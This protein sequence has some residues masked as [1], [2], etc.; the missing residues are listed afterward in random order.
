MNWTDVPRIDQRGAEA[1]PRAVQFRDVGERNSRDGGSGSGG[2]GGGWLR[3]RGFLAVLA[4]G[5]MTLG[6]TVL[7]WIPLAR[8][9]RA[10]E[11]T[12]YLTCGGYSDGPGGPLCV[13]APYS[14]DYCGSDGWFAYGCFSDG[15]GGMDCY[16]P[17]AGCYAESNEARNA[18]RWKADSYTYRCADGR[19]HHD[20]APNPEFVICSAPIAADP[21]PE[22][23]EGQPGT[24]LVPALPSLPSLPSL[25]LR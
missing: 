12:E 17:F 4:T 9:A 25:P 22:K 3:R 20:G 14:A 24:P 15:E 21:A 23:P 18:W 19:I 5:A 1:G 16:E 10:E 13:G 11:G 6:M 8:P 7:G 2:A